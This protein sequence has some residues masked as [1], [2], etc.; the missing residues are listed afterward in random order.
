MINIYNSNTEQHQLETL[1][2]LSILLEQHDTFYEKNVI[3]AGEFNLFFNK[4]IEF[5]RGR[6]ILEKKILGKKD[7]DKRYIKIG[8]PFLYSILM[9]NYFYLFKSNCLCGK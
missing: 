7:R 1:Q 3:L 5:K 6:P 2:N 9:Q 4:K 8:G